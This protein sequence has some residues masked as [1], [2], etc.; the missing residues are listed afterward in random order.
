MTNDRETREMRFVPRM[1][2][3]LGEISPAISTV[4]LVCLVNRGGVQ[5]LSPLEFFVRARFS[6][7]TT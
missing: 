7:T 3:E 1:T 2:P 6:L 4:I 5:K